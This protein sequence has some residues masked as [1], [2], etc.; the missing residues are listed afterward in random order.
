LTAE[1]SE[2]RNR[3]EGGGGGGGKG[4]SEGRANG[5]L[6]NDDEAEIEAEEK[7]HPFEKTL[8]C[9]TLPYSK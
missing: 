4:N 8:G 6:L 9:G 3:R 1:S 2:E 5:V 7:V